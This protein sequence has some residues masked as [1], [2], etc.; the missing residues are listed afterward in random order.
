VRREVPERLWPPPFYSFLLEEALGG[1]PARGEVTVYRGA[2]PDENTIGF[3]REHVGRRPLFVDRVV[4]HRFTLTSLKRR[5]AECFENVLSGIRSK[6]RAGI[7]EV[8]ALGGEDD[9]L[10]R[11]TACSSSNRPALA[12]RERVVIELTDSEVRGA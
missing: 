1:S 7:R 8:S 6:N 9:V 12:Q 11:P 4:S 3:Y 5:V 10:S 2:M